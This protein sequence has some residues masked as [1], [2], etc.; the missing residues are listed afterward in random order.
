M[1]GGHVAIPLPRTHP[2]FICQPLI[3][4]RDVI[5]NFIVI[6]IIGNLLPK[7]IGRRIFQ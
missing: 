3:V 1:K 5:C 7:D 2:E 4:D 6:V